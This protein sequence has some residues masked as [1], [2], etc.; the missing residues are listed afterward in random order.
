MTTVVCL[1]QFHIILI[2]NAYCEL[3]IN[4]F[5]SIKYKVEAFEYLN[6]REMFVH[7][8]KYE[9]K[10]LSKCRVTAWAK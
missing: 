5:N 7:I 8:I 9:W 2:C 3:R 4:L 1:Y 6:N 10:I